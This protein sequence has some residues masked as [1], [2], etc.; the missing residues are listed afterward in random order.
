MGVDRPQVHALTCQDA[1]TGE[2][3]HRVQR[4]G[5][6]GTAAL[7]A[8]G[9]AGGAHFV[10]V[11]IDIAALEPGLHTQAH[12]CGPALGRV[13]DGMSQRHAA[14]LALDPWEVLDIA[15]LYREADA[16]AGHRDQQRLAERLDAVDG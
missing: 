14:T 13:F 15:T 5:A 4:A 8:Q 12:G 3:E 10:E 1:R 2:L 11:E 6:R 16:A 9:R 7:G